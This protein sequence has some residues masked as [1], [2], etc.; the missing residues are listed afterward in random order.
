MTT[1]YYSLLSSQS[2]STK[3]CRLDQTLETQQGY[4]LEKRI[5]TRW[6]GSTPA[7][8]STGVNLLGAITASPPR[9]YPSRS[10]SKLSTAPMR[11]SGSQT[12]LR[13]QP[14][15]HI[16]NPVL[17]V[18]PAN[19]DY[20]IQL[21]TQHTDYRFV[22]A[23]DSD[24]HPFVCQHF[25]DNDFVYSLERTT[26]Q[27]ARHNRDPPPIYARTGIS[28]LDDLRLPHPR[29]VRLVRRAVLARQLTRGV[30]HQR[31][32]LGLSFKHRHRP[33]RK[34]PAAKMSVKTGD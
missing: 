30:Q 17:H 34:Y 25:T 14:S 10:L 22:T 29:T 13:A 26:Q 8:A 20:D 9:N 4:L 1:T 21:D 24:M 27:P 11:T 16:V 32:R 19:N 31:Q 12:R 6:C 3:Q 7:A 23:L 18:K 33:V 15:R 28:G 2:P 5:S